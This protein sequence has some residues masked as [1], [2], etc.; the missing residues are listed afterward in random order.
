MRRTPGYPDSMHCYEPFCTESA[1][2]AA[3]VV[4]P[5]RRPAQKHRNSHRTPHQ[6]KRRRMSDPELLEDTSSPNP[7]RARQRNEHA[8][9]RRWKG[10]RRCNVR[11]PPAVPGTASPHA[12][13][14][15]DSRRAPTPHLRT[16][17]AGTDPTHPHPACTLGTW[18]LVVA[19][20]GNGV[21]H[22][23]IYQ[24]QGDDNG[25]VGRPC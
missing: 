5:R 18:Y 2:H 13:R 14:Y 11:R 12:C 9:R 23:G 21:I 1:P 17:Y 19:Y 15:L 25:H 6:P 3:A 7:P 10:A 24:L 8:C 16:P 4:R 20:R 22:R